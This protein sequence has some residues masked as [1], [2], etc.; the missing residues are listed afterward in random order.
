MRRWPRAAPV[1]E[2]RRRSRFARR[3]LSGLVIIALI[4]SALTPTGCYLSRAGWEE[5][6]IL[7]RRRPIARLVGDTALDAATRAKLRLVL[8]ARDYARYTLGLDVGDSFTT[9]SRL[10]RDTLVLLVSAAHRDRLEEYTWWFPIVGRVPYKGFFDFN[11]ARSLAAQLRREGLDVYMRP[12][13]A[14]STL[15]WFNDPLLSTTLKSDSLELVNTVIHEVTHNT[16]YGAGQAAFN[17]SFANFVGARGAEAFFRARG[18]FAAAE[19]VALRWADEKRLAEFWGVLY[20]S[21]D[22][23]YQAHPGS[24]ETRL[25]ARDTVFARARRTLVHEVGPA[26]RTMPAGY[27]ERVVLDNAALMA[28]R[29]YLTDVELFDRALGRERG[30]LPRTIR[31]IVELAKQ[32]ESDPFAAVRAWVEGPEQDGTPS[33]GQRDDKASGRESAR[34]SAHGDPAVD[35]PTQ[36]PAWR[37]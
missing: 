26:L 29:V 25:E 20:R 15:G 10:D 7:S 18:E 23:A 27:P 34:A 6:K 14:F 22:S 30:D 24:R 28:R 2:P 1:A 31:R 9:Y 11:A 36:A 12:A 33:R 8:E 37:Q 5:A 4:G 17:E 13:S 35:V 21:L 16:Y 32:S 19:E 3:A